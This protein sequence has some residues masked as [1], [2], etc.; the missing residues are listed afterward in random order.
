MPTVAE[1]IRA[2]VD[3]AP[4]L[5]MLSEISSASTAQ[6]RA[7][8]ALALITFCATKTETPIDDDLCQRVKDVLVSEEGAELFRYIVVLVAAVSRT[9]VP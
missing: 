2:L 1:K 5:S 3:W 6:G 4:A 7:E 8:K 9:E